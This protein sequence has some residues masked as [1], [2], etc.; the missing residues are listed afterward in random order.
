MYPLTLKSFSLSTCRRNENKIII[1]TQYYLLNITFYKFVIV[2][3]RLKEVI[4]LKLINDRC[5]DVL[6]TFACAESDQFIHVLD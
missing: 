4:V 3:Q 2:S 6:E 5:F 1:V